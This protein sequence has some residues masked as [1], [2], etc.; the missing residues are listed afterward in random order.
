MSK[1]KYLF[2]TCGWQF[3]SVS[4]DSEMLSKFDNYIDVDQKVTPNG[5]EYDAL[6]TTDGGS[7]AKNPRLYI[8][9]QKVSPYI[10]IDFITLMLA[11][12]IAAMECLGIDIS[13]SPKANDYEN[14]LFYDSKYTISEHMDY[15]LLTHVMYDDAFTDKCVRKGMNPLPV[16][17][18]YVLDK[19]DYHIKS[20]SFSYEA[21][22]VIKNSCMKN[23]G[24]SLERMA[25]L[26]AVMGDVFR[27]WRIVSQD[28]GI[29]AKYLEVVTGNCQIT[30]DGKEQRVGTEL[31]AMEESFE[32]DFLSYAGECDIFPQYGFTQD[33]AGYGDMRGKTAMC[34][35]V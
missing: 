2:S 6:L 31:K 15:Y 17:V 29:S 10:S 19:K 4:S 12:D 5:L 16:K 1:P 25:R 27:A 23:P 21:E 13:G 28:L 7:Y 20:C 11:L 30:L 18:F 8:L 33:E 26:S 14:C 9:R 3:S 22:E 34:I 35:V 24:I 32:N